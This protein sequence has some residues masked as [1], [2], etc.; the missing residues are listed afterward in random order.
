LISVHYQAGLNLDL[1]KPQGY[2]FV[3][4]RCTIPYPTNYLFVDPYYNTFRY[5]AQYNGLLFAAYMFPKTYAPISVQ[6]AALANNIGDKSIPVM[7][8]WESAPN[9]IPGDNSNPNE[10]FV[11][12][13]YD[14][15][16]NHHL[17]TVATIY[18]SKGYWSN[19][20]GAPLSDRPW[21]LV[22]ANWGTNPHGHAS[23]VYP[24]DSSPRWNAFGGL[25]PTI[26]QFGSNIV[27]DG[28]PDPGVVDGDAFRGTLDQLKALHIFK[29]YSTTQP[30]ESLTA[31][32]VH[33]APSFVNP[34]CAVVTW[35]PVPDAAFYYALGD[36][37]PI[38]TSGC[39]AQVP[40]GK[41]IHVRAYAADNRMSPGSNVVAT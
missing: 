11:K 3:T 13:I 5:A 15:L 41:H 4:A 32:T 7:I 37:V 31:P 1:L 22:A 26:L 18:T 36:V 12:A 14:E 19:H 23:A 39:A 20:G 6:C 10:A 27:I 17:L 21:K 35:N 34:D 2:S 9:T 38:F 30:V 16:H 29:D 8:D 24:G 40:H 25:T 33:I 28:Y